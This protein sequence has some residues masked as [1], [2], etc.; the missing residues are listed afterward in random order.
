M[1][2]DPTKPVQ[3]RYGQFKARIV[4]TDARNSIGKVIV[5]LIESIN[6]DVET[7]ECY[8]ADGRWSR[9]KESPIDLINIPPPRR[10]I[11]KNIRQNC[12]GKVQLG[13]TVS[14]SLSEA[15][16]ACGDSLW[17]WDQLEFVYEGDELVDVILHKQEKK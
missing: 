10:S 7:L 3:T 17:F 2:F 13:S 5:A 11:F 12:Y 8:Y 15:R 6:P 1:T 9:S 16:A 4:C 14:F